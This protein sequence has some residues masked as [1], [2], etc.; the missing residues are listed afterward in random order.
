MRIAFYLLGVAC[1]FLVGCAAEVETSSV[2]SAADLPANRFRNVVVFV[3]NINP[4]EQLVAEQS[5][6]SRLKS[7]G[8]RAISSLEVFNYSRAL[9]DDQK[10]AIIRDQKIEAALFV[11]LVRL[12]QVST[13][14]P[15]V[16]YSDGMFH[17]G[18]SFFQW[19]STHS[20]EYSV[21]AQGQVVKETVLVVTQSVLQDVMT[22]KQVWAAE[23]SASVNAKYGDPAGL[24]D[25]ASR[26][27]VAKMRADRAI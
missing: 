27:L 7:S 22:A 5:I 14:V 9:D 24:F 10:A 17:G 16:T 8:V 25:L 3:E 13:P 26:Q 12:Q 4:A 20:L 2:V 21:D 6:A 23:T 15:D 11:T 18:N 1:L 19:H